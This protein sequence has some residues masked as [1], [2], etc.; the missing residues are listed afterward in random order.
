MT[1]GEP[2]VGDGAGAS[3]GGA[4]EGGVDTDGAGIGYGDGVGGGTLAAAG[5]VENVEAS[6][7]GALGCDATGV[8]NC[9]RW[10]KAG[11]KAT[12]HHATARPQIIL[13]V[14]THSPL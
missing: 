1:P 14:F 2:N 6:L 12:H 9:T 10:A 8:A 7:A 3:D 13:A 5:G 11:I 4:E